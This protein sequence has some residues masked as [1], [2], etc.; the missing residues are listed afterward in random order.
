MDFKSIQSVG[1][2]IILLIKYKLHRLL[3]TLLESLWVSQ[4]LPTL[5]STQST[6]ALLPSKNSQSLMNM[7]TMSITLSYSRMHH[8]HLSTTSLRILLGSMD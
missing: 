6:S 8:A 2:K 7:E 4:S 1:E 3:P 5:R